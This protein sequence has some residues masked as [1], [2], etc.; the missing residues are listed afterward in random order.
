VICYYGQF[1]WYFDYFLHSC[2]FN[3]TI[4][5]FIVTDITTYANRLPNNVN[6]VFKTLQ[7]VVCLASEKLGFQVVIDHPYKLCDL[8]PAYGL[9]FSDFLQGYD[10]W[11][12]SDLDIIFGN[13]RNF[14]TDEIL[15]IFDFISIRHDYTTGCFALY[16]NGDFMNNFFKRSKDY[17][18]VFSTKYNYC[19]DECNY[20]HDLLTDG[21]SIFD[22]NTEIESFTEIVR[23]AEQNNEINALFDFMLIEGVPGKIK[24]ENGQVF[25]NN[26]LEGILY[27]LFWLKRV[28]TPKV[29]PANIPDTYFIGPKTIYYKEK[30][31]HLNTALEE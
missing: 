19:F 1:P 11:G 26:K 6:L 2:I 31:R 7:D 4:D 18:K 30:R 12:Q 29:I 20:M 13:I 10:Y 28:Y 14:I 17:K 24:F 8:K 27:H 23:T 16:K 5:I 3:P 15:S 9:I 21:A 22:L 25:Y